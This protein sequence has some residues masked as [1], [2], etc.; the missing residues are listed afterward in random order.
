MEE[1]KESWIEK[2]IELVRQFKKEIWKTVYDS[3]MYIYDDEL[4]LILIGEKWEM[5]IDSIDIFRLLFG[6]TFIQWLVDNDKIDRTDIPTWFDYEY[7]WRKDVYCVSYE[8][9]ILTMRLSIQDEPIQ[10][11]I[12]ILR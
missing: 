4:Q 10:F 3:S 5:F 8:V 11:L 7:Q 6:S 12:S 1:K 9:N 2:L